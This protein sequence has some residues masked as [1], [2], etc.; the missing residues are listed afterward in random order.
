MILTEEESTGRRTCPIAI[1]SAINPTD[2][3]GIKFRPSAVRG[4]QD[5]IFRGQ[6]SIGVHSDMT[7]C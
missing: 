1:L 5:F 3:P 7:D 2:C 4:M 6:T